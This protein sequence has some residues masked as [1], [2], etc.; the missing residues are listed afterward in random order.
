MRRLAIAAGIAALLSA[1]CTAAPTEIATLRNETG[2]PGD[3][4]TVTRLRSEPYSFA[5]Y[6]GMKDPAQVVVRTQAEWA[7]VWSAVWGGSS[8]VPPLPQVDFEREVVV[9]AALGTRATGGFSIFVDGAY[10][11]EGFV[12]VVI[13]KVSPGS[14]CATTQA[15]TQPVDLARIAIAGQPVQF[16]ERASVHDCG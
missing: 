2:A 5:Y 8:P 11:R 4:V 7:Q 3:P 10:Q 14:R 16:S 1:G 9:A 13:H 6:S 15:L 12:E